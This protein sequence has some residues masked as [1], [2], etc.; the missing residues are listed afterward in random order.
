MVIFRRLIEAP[1][2]YDLLCTSDFID[3]DVVRVGVHMDDGLI[4]CL[5]RSYSH[6]ELLRRNHRVLDWQWF[7]RRTCPNYPH[8]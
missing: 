7:T 4:G 5:G 1:I 8:C 6:V 3:W 2:A